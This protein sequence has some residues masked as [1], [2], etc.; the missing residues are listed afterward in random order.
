MKGLENIKLPGWGDKNPQQQ[1]NINEGVEQFRATPGAVLVDVRD[2]S[3]FNSGHIPG[4]INC[5]LS[6]IKDVAFSKDTTLFLYCL[7]GVR[8]KRAAA[9]LR[10]LGYTD[11]YSIGGIKQY[12]GALE[13]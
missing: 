2:A 11:V 5:P 9:A 12:T 8:S 4:A 1:E 7:S 6:T 13:K 10:Q 3:E